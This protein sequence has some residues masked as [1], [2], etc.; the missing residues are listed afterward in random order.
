MEY[1][2]LI[3][4][5][6]FQTVQSLKNL[7]FWSNLNCKVNHVAYNADDAMKICMQTHI[8]LVITDIKMPGT[9]GLAFANQLYKLFPEVIIIAIS[10]FDEFNLVKK[11]LSLGLFDYILKPISDNDLYN[12]VRRAVTFMNKNN[13]LHDNVNINMNS[14]DI[15]TPKQK[16]IAIKK[17]NDSFHN[18]IIHY[19]KYE[20]EEPDNISFFSNKD[21]GFAIICVGNPDQSTLDLIKSNNLKT[22]FHSVCDKFVNRGVDYYLLTEI[23]NKFYILIFFSED[24]NSNSQ[25]SLLKK[26]CI[27]LTNSDITTYNLFCAVSKIHHNSNHFK[28]AIYEVNTSYDMCYFNKDRRV[29]FATDNTIL[30]NYNS[31]RIMGKCCT[32]FSVLKG[33]TGNV[34]NISLE[35]FEELATQHNNNPQE[36]KNIL[37]CICSNIYQIYIDNTIFIDNEINLTQIFNSIN[38]STNFMDTQNLV[39]NLIYSTHDKLQNKQTTAYSKTVAEILNYINTNYQQKITLNDISSEFNF[40]VEYIC[41][42][43]K[44]E[45]KTT[46]TNILNQVRIKN[47]EQLLHETDMKVYEIANLVGFENYAYFYQTYKKIT[48]RTPR[49]N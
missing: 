32:L 12:T 26:L 30:A 24:I 36:V 6:N 33:S 1:N 23:E 31:Y 8:D 37:I 9:D 48:N 35:I 34:K 42:L 7:T 41:R 28:K 45:T 19:S 40:S 44:K 47:A 38:N 4:D 2:V 22:C 5:D 16:S 3:I 14:N 10:A 21:N 20:E 15:L 25:N 11:A 13:E 43:L 29:L 39:L 17:E 46:F 18:F 49:H 27:N